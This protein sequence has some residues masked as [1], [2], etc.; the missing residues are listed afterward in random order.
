MSDRFEET[1][2]R[3]ELRGLDPAW[4]AEILALASAPHR[5]QSLPVIKLAIAA[6]WIAIG[7]LNLSMPA[8][9]PEIATQPE[10]RPSTAQ[11]L[12][13]IYLLAVYTREIDSYD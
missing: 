4:K 3:V 11:H 9:D 13:S 7:I 6:S 2:S 1:L 12:S 10:L 5:K 8:G